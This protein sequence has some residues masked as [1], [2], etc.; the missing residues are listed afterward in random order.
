MEDFVRRLNE[1]RERSE[2]AAREDGTRWAKEKA[3]YWDLTRLSRVDLAGFDNDRDTDAS[4]LGEWVENQI[5]RGMLDSIFP[6]NDYPSEEYV[7]AFVDGAL[8]V[9]EEYRVPRVHGLRSV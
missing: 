9:L 5:G 6:G 8:E 1:S 2:G 7:V 4:T 3:E